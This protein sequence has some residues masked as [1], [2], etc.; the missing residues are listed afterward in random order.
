[1]R[2]ALAQRSRLERLDIGAQTEQL[3]DRMVEFSRLKD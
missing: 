3:A 2:Q 1:V